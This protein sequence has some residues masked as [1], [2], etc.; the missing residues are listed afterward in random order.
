MHSRF[1]LCSVALNKKGMQDLRRDV[2]Y[3]EIMGT[4]RELIEHRAVF[5]NTL[6]RAKKAVCVTTA[7]CLNLALIVLGADMTQSVLANFY[8]FILF[9]TLYVICSC[10][11]R[12]CR[13]YVGACVQWVATVVVR[14]SV[15]TPPT[16]EEL[17]TCFVVVG[18][19][20]GEELRALAS[21]EERRIAFSLAIADCWFAYRSFFEG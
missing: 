20:L 16:T 2:L 15:F 17:R 10:I 13:R 8:M 4:A 19:Y 14:C 12:F 6:I 7:L 18:E 9:L 5:D 11:L 3:A 1:S 21:A